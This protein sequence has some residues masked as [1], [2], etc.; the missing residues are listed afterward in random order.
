V[1][2]DFVEN[3]TTQTRKGLLELGVLNAIRERRRYGYEIVRLLQAVPGLVI[4]EGTIYPILGRLER[5]GL[6]TASLEPSPQG[7]A[8]KY[9]RLTPRGRAVLAAMN[10]RWDAIGRGIQEIRSEDHGGDD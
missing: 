3:W 4:S 1:S 9:Y 6:T 5:D 7:P 8:R 2:E 10:E